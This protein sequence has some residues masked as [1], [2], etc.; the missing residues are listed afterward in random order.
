M[1]AGL[2]ANALFAAGAAR[3]PPAQTGEGRGMTA[4]V[5]P[6]PPLYDEHSRVLLL[7]T[8]PSPASRENAFYYGHP[9]N[10]FW[11]VMAAVFDAPL[12]RANEERAAFALAKNIALWDV[13]ASCSIEG[14]ADHTIKAPRANDLLPLLRKTAVTRIFTTG[15][16]AAALYAQLCF[17]QTGIAAT[18]LPST[19][20]ANRQY[21]FARLVEA[22]RA[23][24]LAV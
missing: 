24:R 1:S 6:F 11:P 21:S 18:A 19:S 13:L 4:V 9:R 10:R 23:V 12:P 20:P 5:H 3:G 17:A 16:K 2:G 8:M 7:G 14:A 15:K 22:Y